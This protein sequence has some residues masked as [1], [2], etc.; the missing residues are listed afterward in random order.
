MIAAA[1][2]KMSRSSALKIRTLRES[3]SGPD[4]PCFVEP[5]GGRPAAIARCRVWPHPG[6]GMRAWRVL[7][8][9]IAMY[10]LAL[11][12]RVLAKW[13]NTWSGLHAIGRFTGGSVTTEA[14]RNPGNVAFATTNS[15][16]NPFA[17]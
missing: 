14:F 10:G 6:E 17:F 11:D 3:A 2:E 16:M 4:G 1:E 9:P 12:E 13:L 5:V 7:P 15:I 8:N